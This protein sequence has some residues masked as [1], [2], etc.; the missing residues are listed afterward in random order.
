MGIWWPAMGCLVLAGCFP[1]D[2]D[3]QPYSPV[4]AIDDTAYGG[5]DEPLVATWVSE[6]ADRSTLFA[7]EPFLYDSVVTTF[8]G[9]GTYLA[10]L[11]DQDAVT[12]DLSGTWT[13]TDGA[14]GSITLS[15]TEPYVATA[16]GIWQIDA[17]TLTYEV[18]Q[19]LPD[20]GYAPPT[21]STGFGSTT[22]PGLTPGINVQTY[23]RR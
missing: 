2:W 6:G 11:T 4:P 23:R 7:A 9:S 15:Q 18:V 8:D 5:T 14:P 12:Y 16:E 20:Y 13:A 22:G 21:P 17:D 1:D 19:T 10:T 3:G